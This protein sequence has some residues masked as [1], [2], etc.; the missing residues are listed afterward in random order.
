MPRDVCYCRNQ[1]LRHVPADRA[2]FVRWYFATPAMTARRVVVPSKVLPRYAED[3][4]NRGA[5]I[6]W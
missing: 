1:S 2:S 5:C 6:C 3:G 4:D